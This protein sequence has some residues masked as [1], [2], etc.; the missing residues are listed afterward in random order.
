MMRPICIR[1]PDGSI[2][3]SCMLK[4]H[5]TCTPPVDDG[6]ISDNEVVLVQAMEETPSED[7]DWRGLRRLDHPLYLH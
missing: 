4:D 3:Y 5:A 1:N 7:N 6:S 2:P